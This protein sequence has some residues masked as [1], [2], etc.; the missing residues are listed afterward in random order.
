[1]RWIGLRLDP[2]QV[3]TTSRN[4]SRGVARIAAHQ[5][6]QPSRKIH[7]WATFLTTVQRKRRRQHPVFYIVHRAQL[8]RSNQTRCDGARSSISPNCPNCPKNHQHG[9]NNPLASL[10]QLCFVIRLLRTSPRGTKFVAKQHLD[11]AP[12]TI[13]LRSSLRRFE[14]RFRILPLTS[15]RLG[16][17]IVTA[18]TGHQPAQ[19][20]SQKN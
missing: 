1:L 18:G 9:A 5:Y 17:C 10:A 4:R 14:S 12:S 11:V 19:A 3:F 2:S 7:A 6:K 13:T 15:I 20:P 8:L 16:G